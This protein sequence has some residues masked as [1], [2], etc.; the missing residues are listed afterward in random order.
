MSVPPVD[1]PPTIR[2]APQAARTQSAEEIRRLRALPYA[3]YLQ[4]PWW[5]AR[6]NRALRAAGYRCQRCT[7]KRQLEVHHQSYE[8]LGDELDSDLEVVCRGCHVG[9]HFNETQDA[10]GLYMRIVSDVLAEDRFD[11]VSDAIEEAK[12]RCATW[13]INY[14]TT[15]FHAAVARLIARFPFRAPKGKAELYRVGEATEPLSKAE[16]AGIVARLQAAGLLKHMPQVQ[17]L[18]VR[19]TECQRA[20]KILAQAILD[21]VERCE[22]L[23]QQVPG[24]EDE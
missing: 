4:T 12:R 24:I 20:A 23:E 18:T 5:R 16:A 11:D 13:K 14:D 22:A 21:Q 10:I 8:R 15:Q 3:D 2:S 17:P 9:H 6:R 1:V 19:E 7:V